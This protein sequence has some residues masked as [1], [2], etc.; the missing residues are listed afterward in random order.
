M[1]FAV[2]PG[3]SSLNGGDGVLPSSLIPEGMCVQKAGHMLWHRHCR[4]IPLTV[5][6][7]GPIRPCAD[8]GKCGDGLRVLGEGG[9]GPGQFGDKLRVDGGSP[10]ATDTGCTADRNDIRW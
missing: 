6:A 8:A 5:L 7:K 4:L 9:H 10:L 1:A 3:P 2:S